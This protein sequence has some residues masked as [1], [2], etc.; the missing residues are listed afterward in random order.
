MRRL[1]DGEDIGKKKNAQG[2]GRTYDIT[3]A[4]PRSLTET[5]ELTAVRN[6]HYATQAVM[7]MFDRLFVIIIRRSINAESIDIII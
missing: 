2:R 3:V 5:P 4:K 1:I 6:N 7:I